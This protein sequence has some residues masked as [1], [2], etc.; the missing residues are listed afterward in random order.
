MNRWIL[1]PLDLFLTLI[2]KRASNSLDPIM[3]LFEK[4]EI[5]SLQFEESYGRVYIDQMMLQDRVVVSFYPN[6][7]AIDQIRQVELNLESAKRNVKV[8]SS[9]VKNF[10]KHLGDH[11]GKFV[12]SKYRNDQ[13]KE[14]FKDNVSAVKLNEY[15]NGTKTIENIT[16]R[17]FIKMFFEFLDEVDVDD[18]IIRS[19]ISQEGLKVCYKLIYNYLK[20][21]VSA[22]KK[23]MNTLDNIIC[24]E[25]ERYWP[26]IKV[27]IRQDELKI[28]E[29]SDITNSS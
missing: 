16:V 26:I 19:R 29:K 7:K 11:F 5:R 21:T 28:E 22:L 17:A 18:A 20:C 24:M 4:D 25:F 12:S 1:L 15:L 2:Q 14:I 8:N 3:P 6:Y 10:N 9:F 13:I 27:S 23:W